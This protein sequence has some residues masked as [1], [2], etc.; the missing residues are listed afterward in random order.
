MGAFRLN[1]SIIRLARSIFLSNSPISSMD[2]WGGL[3]AVGRDPVQLVPRRAHNTADF[4]IQANPIR[5]QAS[6]PEDAVRKTP[7]LR[8]RIR[9]PAGAAGLLRAGRQSRRFA[10]LLES[11]ARR[12]F[13]RFSSALVPRQW[14]RACSQGNHL[15]VDK[16]P[17]L[18]RTGHR[19]GSSEGDAGR[20]D[21]VAARMAWM[22][23]SGLYGI[24]N[25]EWMVPAGSRKVMVL[26]DVHTA[27]SN[28]Q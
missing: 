8:R 10:R 19:P 17:F 13:P 7:L 25:V 4:S 2:A 24:L 15:P 3:T 14:K 28:P 16:L 5:Q 27:W 11:S 23:R 1:S 26:P 9:H 20:P 22:N 12:S 6:I 21:S 18:P